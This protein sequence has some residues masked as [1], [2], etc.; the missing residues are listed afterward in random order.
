MHKL[1][2][3][4]VIDEQKLSWGSS[5]NLINVDW[6][7]IDKITVCNLNE[8]HL[9]RH[10]LPIT[11]STLNPELGWDYEFTI[12]SKP[13][14]INGPITLSADDYAVKHSELTK[15]LK[16]KAMLNNFKLENS[17]PE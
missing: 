14:Y 12:K 10:F 11:P 6:A 13:S 8:P 1:S 16:N 2:Y 4:L 5:K 17:Q 7:E 9:R 15:I 3:K